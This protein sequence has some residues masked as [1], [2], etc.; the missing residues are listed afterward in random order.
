MRLALALMLWVVPMRPVLAPPYSDAVELTITGRS[1][2]STASDSAALRAA[3]DSLR[4]MRAPADGW[5]A[6]AVPTS[7][8]GRIRMV[9][10]I[11]DGRW[12]PPHT[13]NLSKRLTVLE[14][15]LLVGHGEH[16]TPGGAARERLTAGAT[17]EMPARVVH[18][19][20]A[21]GRALVLLDAAA[22]LTTTWVGR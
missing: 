1:Q 14:G 11:D 20:G 3:V 15:T 12:I 9:L 16:I 13:H 6:L 2:P 17:T 21:E 8:T 5:T 18:F 7:E 19:E 22:G 4:R 10:R